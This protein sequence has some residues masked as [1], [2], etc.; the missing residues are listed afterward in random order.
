MNFNSSSSV[1]RAR[2]NHID[3]AYKFNFQESHQFGLLD[4]E[5]CYSGINSSQ[6]DS[7]EICLMYSHPEGKACPAAPALEEWQVCNNHPCTVFYWEASAWG[8]CVEDTSSDI[9]GTSLNNGTASC[10]VGV[11]SRKVSCLKMH[12]GPVMNKRYAFRPCFIVIACQGLCCQIW[13]RYD[14]RAYAEICFACEYLPRK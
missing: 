10:A 4:A 9:N 13:S 6:F 2:E 5:P 12:A 8:P 11:Q 1:Q 3:S 7:F 14:H